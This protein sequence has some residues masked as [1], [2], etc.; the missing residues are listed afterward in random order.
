MRFQRVKGNRSNYLTPKGPGKRKSPERAA[1]LGQAM[2]ERVMCDGGPT[3]ATKCGAEHARLQDAENDAKAALDAAKALV[4]LQYTRER[5]LDR[6]EANRAFLD[7][8]RARQ[9]FERK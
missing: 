4:T 8:C 6:A 3:V 9:D 2:S 7:A 5:F 1:E